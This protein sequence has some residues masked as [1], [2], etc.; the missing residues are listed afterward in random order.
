MIADL[1]FDFHDRY[2][3]SVLY[4]FVLCF[5]NFNFL[6]LKRKKKLIIVFI[7]SVISENNF[8]FDK[9]ILIN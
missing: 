6:F 5:T 9:E 7:K 1:R 4:Y 8:A 3:F 2:S